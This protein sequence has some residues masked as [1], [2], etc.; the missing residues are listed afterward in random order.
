MA[1]DALESAEDYLERI[2]ML[3][4]EGMTEIHAVDLASSFGYSKASISIAL[5]KLEEK[6]YVA[7]GLKSQLYLTPAGYQ[8]AKKVYE[9]HK[10]ISDWLMSI[11]VSKEVA[12]KDAC[13]MEHIISEES[14]EALKKNI[15]ENKKDS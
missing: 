10:V 7:L 12:L 8:I 14:F 3:Q 5:H 6:G 15:A 4:E 11:G 1:I 13:R 2:L 9:K